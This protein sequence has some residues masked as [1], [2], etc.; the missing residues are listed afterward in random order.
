MQDDTIVE[1]LRDTPELYSADDITKLKWLLDKDCSID[2]ICAYFR[3]V[4]G[5]YD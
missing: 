3:S 1:E 2:A 5:S 4:N